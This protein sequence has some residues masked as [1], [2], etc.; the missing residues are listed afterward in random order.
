MPGMQ[1]Q[2]LWKT[3]MGSSAMLPELHK[4]LE[5]RRNNAVRR[6]GANN[7][8]VLG[9]SGRDKD[10][11]WWL[12]HFGIFIEPNT[13]CFTGGHAG[14]SSFKVWEFRYG[15]PVFNIGYSPVIGRLWTLMQEMTR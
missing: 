11:D 7:D 8:A 14:V 5:V 2:M 3:E 13:D 12:Q 15:I 4:D 6:A 10:R 9:S 1:K